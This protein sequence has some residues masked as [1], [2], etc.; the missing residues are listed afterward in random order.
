MPPVELIIVVP[1][2]LRMFQ[3]HGAHSMA[4]LSHCTMAAADKGLFWRQVRPGGL[5]D[6]P[7]PGAA[8][9]GIVMAGPNSFGLPPRRLPGSILRSQALRASFALLAPSGSRSMVDSRRRSPTSAKLAFLVLP[10]SRAPTCARKCSESS[11]GELQGCMHVLKTLS[12]LFPHGFRVAH[13]VAGSERIA[14]RV[15]GRWRMYVLRRWR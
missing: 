5:L 15:A 7:Q 2:D 14:Y 6:A 13:R 4:A 9:R 3:A 10:C 12:S 8:P 11:H 1:L